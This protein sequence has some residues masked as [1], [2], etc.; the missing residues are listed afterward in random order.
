MCRRSLLALGVAGVCMT[1]QV[2][3]ADAETALSPELR[4]H[5]APWATIAI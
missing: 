2:Q 5:C 3:T 4:E 1:Q